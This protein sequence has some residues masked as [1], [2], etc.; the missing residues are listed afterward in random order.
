MPLSRNS[1]HKDT[2]FLLIDKHFTSFLRISPRITEQD[3]EQCTSSHRKRIIKVT[4]DTDRGD[5]GKSRRNQHLRSIR[6][7]SLYQAGECIEDAGGFSAVEMKLL[8]NILGYRPCCDNGDGVVGSTQIGNAYQGGNTQFRPSLAVDVTG[9]FLPF[10][11]FRFPWLQ[12]SR[13]LRNFR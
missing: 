11:L 5:I 3:S 12:T 6:N 13:I 1:G 7:N 2:A 8:G 10:P 9:K 4:D